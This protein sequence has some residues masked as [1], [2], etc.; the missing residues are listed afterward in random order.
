MIGEDAALTQVTP[1]TQIIAPDEFETAMDELLTATMALA[2]AIAEI[3][4]LKGVRLRG[5]LERALSRAQA[6]AEQLPS[7]SRRAEALHQLADMH[8]IATRLLMNAPAPCAAA[9]AGIEAGDARSW[10]EEARAWAAGRSALGVSPPSGPGT[11][12][13]GVR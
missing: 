2:S 9:I 7:G 1:G 6:L 3:A 12:K 5:V 10:N 11:N 8:S 4:F 13:V